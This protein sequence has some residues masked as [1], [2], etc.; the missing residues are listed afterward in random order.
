MWFCYSPFAG[1]CHLLTRPDT[2]PPPLAASGT[3][4]PSETRRASRAFFANAKTAA[5]PW[6]VEAEWV[7]NRDSIRLART[8]DA[9]LRL[10][11]LRLRP[12]SR[13]RS[14]L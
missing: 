9:G 11:R 1:G 10:A 5:V 2:I 6:L 4:F 8:T 7:V 12:T 3:Y 13:T 14:L